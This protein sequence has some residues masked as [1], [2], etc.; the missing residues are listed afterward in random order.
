[1]IM[2]LTPFNNNN[3]VSGS[4]YVI[5]FSPPNMTN[6]F[7]VWKVDYNLYRSLNW[8]GNSFGTI[9]G[10]GDINLAGMQSLGWE[11]HGTNA[12]PLFAS[13]LYYDTN[14]VQNSYSLTA[15]SPARNHGT[16]N[17]LPAN[18][19]AAITNSEGKVDLG[20]YQH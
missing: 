17:G 4:S 13:V 1:M 6:L 19:I 3:G 15:S 8:S 16:T 10:H 18:I 20:C 7:S 5:N 2:G 9:T 11:L 14:A 12:E